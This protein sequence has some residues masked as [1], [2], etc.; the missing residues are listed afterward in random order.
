VTP[1][2]PI[3]VDLAQKETVRGS[4]LLGSTASGSAAGDAIQP[5][6]SSSDLFAAPK[7]SGPKPTPPA[8]PSTAKAP[9]PSAASPEKKKLVSLGPLAAS[10]AQLVAF[11]VKLETPATQ[12]LQFAAPGSA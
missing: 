6:D 11:V 10:G 7:R 2:H 3:P 1:A 5:P 12:L 4:S 9:R 8:G